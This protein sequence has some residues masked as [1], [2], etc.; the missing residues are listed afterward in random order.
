MENNEMVTT[1]ETV[2]ETKADVQTEQTTETKEIKKEKFYTREEVERIKKA[3][4][5]AIL[6]EE[7]IKRTEAEKLASMKTEEKLKYQLEKEQKEKEQLLKK[8]NASELKDEALKIATSP[9]TQFDVDFLNLI[10]FE[11]IDADSLNEKTKLIKKVQDK[12]IA[13][14]I[15]E[16]SKEPA[17]QTGEQ[18]KANLSGFEKFLE[19][20]K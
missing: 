20:N 9:E 14:A 6:E 1:T 8:I 4:R 5:E 2:E 13:K 11:R 16:F 7:K 18:K 17:P 12:L 10:D 3:E 19:N 15:S